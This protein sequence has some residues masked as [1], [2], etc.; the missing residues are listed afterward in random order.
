MFS[1]PGSIEVRMMDASSLIGFASS[2]TGALENVSASSWEMKVSD[3]AS[4]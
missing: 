3:T 4:L 2:M 1:I